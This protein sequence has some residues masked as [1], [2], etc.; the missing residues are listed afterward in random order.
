ME[1]NGQKKDIKKEKY[2]E[3]ELTK[4]HIEA[5]AADNLN[6]LELANKINECKTALNILLQEK[7]PGLIMQ[8]KIKDY[9]GEKSNSYFPNLVARNKVK[10]T[11]TKL[12]KSDNTFTTDTKE[13][14]LKQAKFFGHLYKTKS[15]K[16]TK[17]I[18][19]YLDKVKSVSLSEFEKL[20]CEGPLTEE[21]CL[22]TL[23][24]FFH[25]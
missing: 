20:L 16:T 9:E 21:E 1:K 2:L 23:K 3:S 8:S 25:K 15:Q 7:A 6:Q 10:K 22:E 4:L 5:A 12:M 24:T 13:I 17:E 11:M 14:A 19:T 18:E